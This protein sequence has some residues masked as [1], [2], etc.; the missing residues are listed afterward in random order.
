M[1]KRNAIH[2]RL[3]WRRPQLTIKANPQHRR[4]Q[5]CHQS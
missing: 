3:I 5:H 4:L 1:V 2:N